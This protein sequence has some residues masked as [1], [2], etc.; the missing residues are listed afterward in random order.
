MNPEYQYESLSTREGFNVSLRHFKLTGVFIEMMSQG[1][2]LADIIN[3]Q[4]SEGG[5]TQSQILPTL[6]ALLTQKYSYISK[7]LNLISVEK[8]LEKISEETSKW[9]ALDLV[10]L[11]HHP[12]M[13]TLV[14]NPKNTEDWKM[15]SNLRNHELLIVFAG[16]SVSN[17]EFIKNKGS[18]DLLNTGIKKIFDL[19][20][21][22]KTRIPAN[23][24]EG[25]IT[26]KILKTKVEELKPELKKRG[27]K[28]SAKTKLKSSD[29]VN[30]EN[31]VLSSARSSSSPSIRPISTPTPSVARIQGPVPG[32]KMT[33]V[34][35]LGVVVSNEL[36][37]NG[38][39]EAWKRIIDSYTAK[40]PTCIVTIYY[41][42]EVI[43]DINSLFKW[44]KVKHGTAIEFSVMGPGEKLNDV[45]KLKR[46]LSDGA[47]SRYEMFL[48]GPVGKILEL[49]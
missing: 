6:Q 37:H 1:Y 43:K 28:S 47:S 18:L 31:I 34:G 25:K 32:G 7:S 40:Y 8:Q 27:P 26:K 48:K 35:P 2:N 4:L 3:Q 10:V 11:Y 45:A 41:D 14:V 20:Q 46:Y 21:G 23:L 38:N 19:A 30:E 33:K 5:I 16:T 22:V 9:K 49:F 44:G 39:V 42:G 24:L 15:V 12:E 17:P 29:T 13:G 36:F